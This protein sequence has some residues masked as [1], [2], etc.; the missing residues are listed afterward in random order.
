MSLMQAS[1]KLLNHSINLITTLVIVTKEPSLTP[2]NS[3]GPSPA[4][5]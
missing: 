4:V 2:Q 1:H 5:C 3:A